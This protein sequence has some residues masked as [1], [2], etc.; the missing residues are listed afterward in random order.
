MQK[1]EYHTVLLM[2]SMGISGRVKC[3][4]LKAINEKNVPHWRKAEE[5][6]SLSV[7]CNQMGQEGWELA[8]T[9][10]DKYNTDCLLFFKRQLE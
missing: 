8:S 6:S 9:E 3:W 5:C 1:W 4:R 7:F 2:L 10:R